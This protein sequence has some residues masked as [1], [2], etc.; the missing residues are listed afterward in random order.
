[1]KFFKISLAAITFSLF[2]L[3]AIGSSND[4]DE[5]AYYQSTVYLL[6]Q[7]TDAES[8]SRNLLGISPRAPYDTGLSNSLIEQVLNN[9]T[10][11]NNASGLQRQK[12]AYI[13]DIIKQNKSI[14]C[15]GKLAAG[16]LAS[17][18]ALISGGTY[19]Y[20]NVSDQDKFNEQSILPHESIILQGIIYSIS[21]GMFYYSWKFLQKTTNYLPIYTEKLE[22]YKKNYLI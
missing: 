14:I 8:T 5:A 17:L 20:F 22:K 1:M 15:N 13:G 18:A 6:N 21:M 11:I 4:D 3:L 12:E 2:S 7:V 9:A 10:S 16:T 19:Y